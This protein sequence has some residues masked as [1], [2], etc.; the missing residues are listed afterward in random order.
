MIEDEEICS[1]GKYEV[2]HISS[3]FLKNGQ[4]THSDPSPLDQ[5]K[6][7]SLPVDQA[8]VKD[9]SFSSDINEV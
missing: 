6:L 4:K 3:P 5:T 1:C 9:C 8:T 7:V 2:F